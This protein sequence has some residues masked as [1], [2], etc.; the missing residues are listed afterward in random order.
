MNKGTVKARPDTKLFSDF[1]KK[2]SF[3]IP[4]SHKT[5]FSSRDL[6][7]FLKSRFKFFKVHKHDV[8]ISAYNPDTEFLWLAN[9]S[10]IEILMPDSPFIVDTI[11]DYCNANNYSVQ[12]IIHPIFNVERTEAGTLKT[13]DYSGGR[14]S[15]ESYVYLE[16]NRLTLT[17]LMELKKNIAANLKELRQ[18][19]TDYRRMLPL[20][21][22]MKVEEE[23]VREELLWLK[24]NFVLLGLA[25]VEEHS[26]NG[27]YLGLFRKARVRDSVA[28]ELSFAQSLNQHAAILY[29][30]T[31]IHSN[32]NKNRQLYLVLVHDGRKTYIL[33]GHFRHRAEIDLRVNVPTIRRIVERMATELKVPPTS[34]MRKELY[35]TAQALPVGFMLTR[36]RDLLFGWFVKVISNMYTTSVSHMI[37]LDEEYQLV[38]AEVILPL[39]Y[40]GQIP[41]QGLRRFLR[42]HGIENPYEFR[43]RLNQIEVVFLGFRAET[44][45]PSELF[46]LL[47]ENADDLLSTWSSRFKELVYKKY[48]GGRAIDERLERFVNGMA[49]DYEIHQEPEETLYDLDTLETLDSTVGEEGF[50]VVYRANFQTQG[51]IKIYATRATELS[52]LI[53]ILTSFGFTVSEQKAF[54][55]CRDGE[56]RF[57]YVFRVPPKELSHAEQARISEALRATLNRQTTAKPINELV[58][59]AGLTVRQLDLLKA[60]CSYFYK[61]NTSFSFFS[62]QKTLVN[63]PRFASNLVAFFEAR[64]NEK[65]NRKEVSECHKAIVRSFGDLR[66]V[67]DENICKALLNV[68][69]SI[70]RTNY[71]LNK[72]EISF[73]IRGGAIESIPKPVPYFEIFV[74]ANDMEAI[75]L[76]GGAVARGGIRWSDRQDDFRTEVLGLMKAQM[77]K[78]TVIVPVGS[79]GGF[80]LKNRDFTSR[81]QFLA[82][83]VD[84]YKRF[85]SCLLELTDNLSASGT[86]VPAAGIRRLDGDDTYLVVAADKGTATFSDIANEISER[87][88][89]WLTDAFASGGSEGFDHKKQ[90]ITA[91]GAWESVKRHFHEIGIDPGIDR[92]TAV[93]IGDM[94]GDVFGN[95]FI[96]SP[97]VQLIAAFNHLHIFLDPGPNIDASYQE[98]LRLFN[99]GKNWDE[100]DVGIISEG[101]GVFPRASR[102]IKLTAQVRAAL[103]IK[104]ASLSG[105][106]VIQAILCAP[107]DLLWNGGIGTYVKATS[108]SHHQAGDPANDRVRVDAPSLRA[109]VIGEG[110]NLGLTQAARIEAAECGVRL[111]TDAIDNS[112]GVNMSDHEVNL[113]IL[114][115]VMQ[116]RKVIRD[117]KERNRLIRRYEQ[118]EIDLV[119]SHNYK[120]NLGISL[121][122][123]RV[124]SQ[125]LYFRSLIKFLNQKGIIDRKRDSIPF[126][127]EIDKLQD[128]SRVLPRPLLCALAGYTKL[129]GTQIFLESD[130]FRDPWFD[131]FIVRYF[132]A[133]LSRKYSKFILNH[134]LKREIIITE[135]INEVVNYAG[136][137]FF[138]RMVMA[139]GKSPMEVGKCYMVLS[140][141]LNLSS[142]RSR[143]EIPGG[144]INANIY[145]EYMI[146]LEEKVFQIARKVLQTDGLLQ[147]VM[148]SASGTFGKMLEEASHHSTFRLDRKIRILFRLLSEEDSGHIMNAFRHVDTLEDT[149]NIYLNNKSKQTKWQVNEY[150]AVLQQYRI[151]ELR[152]IIKQLKASSSWEVLFFSKVDISIENLIASLVRFREQKGPEAAG[153]RQRTKILINEIINLHARGDLS[154]AS[155]FEMLQFAKDRILGEQA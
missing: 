97:S 33:A 91:R 73:K 85:I 24:E 28:K 105:E 2:Y 112:A 53:P 35:K 49:P 71:F 9:S 22:S 92:I 6:D 99:A 34:Y 13:L 101:G 65:T 109:K 146:Q 17:E 124:P 62:I 98:R 76:R 19:V 118:N 89:F 147:V 69:E 56:E 77:V 94:S 1:S 20:L 75:H 141:F 59:V 43:Y 90:G 114:L 60:V 5:F 52:E 107:V 129:Y 135:V 131:R 72:P 149:F 96:L 134:P 63:Y 10:V 67:L 16:I 151:R 66:S 137:A 29:H 108:E 78:N 102:N 3:Y 113:K 11:V 138:Q 12:L 121:D 80:V 57:T 100:Y 61:I 79:K 30:E 95:A 153:K 122:M 127:S 55:Y 47:T 64:F 152:K 44:L 81:E 125:F 133:G 116:R 123:R 4:E 54:P 86:V 126:E 150:F 50:K 119:L 103:G 120:N 23:G 14:G 82:A 45:L 31:E 140:E 104:T 38:W 155:Y 68:V 83:G 110:G 84:A 46:G 128:G 18:V 142:L 37:S 40:A 143:V 42:Q 39:A 106:E 115:N 51:Q 148:E 93:G 136:I 41:H 36:S 25:P 87:K 32:V 130:N 70:V 48:E 88:K 145:Y 111:N 26:L 144:W 74:Y 117:R 8:E 27:K 139:T 58:R 21:E 154:P 132:P 7:L 15:A